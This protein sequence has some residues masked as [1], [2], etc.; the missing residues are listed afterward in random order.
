MGIEPAN[1]L[2]DGNG[3]P[4]SS[5]YQDSYYSRKNGLEES[6]YV[7]I[8][9]NKL[10]QNWRNKHNFTIAETGFG[11]GLNFLAT[12]QYWKNT[13][14]HP[15]Q[16]H[17]ISIEKHPLTR[18]QLKSTLARWHELNAFSALLLDQ[19]PEL[20]PGFHRLHFENHKITLTLC[21]MPANEALEQLDYPIDAWYLDGFS[22][23]KNPD[24]WNYTI[25][26]SIANLSHEKTTLATFTA[27]SLV[28]KQL[29]EAEFNVSKRKGFGKKREMLIATY[30][31]PF[32]SSLPSWFQNTSQNIGK[33]EATLIGGGI[34][35]CQAAWHLAQ[36]G[37]KITLIERHAKLAQEASGNKAGVIT[38]KMTAKE[39]PGETFYIQSFFYV[40]QQLKQLSSDN[41]QTIHWSMSGALQL[42]HNVR[43]S[44]RWQA[45]QERQL[46]LTFLQCVD[47]KKA[48]QIAS[49]SLPTGA[50]YFPQA[51]WLNPASL[52]EALCLHEN[53]SVIYETEALRLEKQNNKWRLKDENDQTI[54]E[55]S[56]VIIANGKDADTFS[57]TQ[58]LPFQPVAGQTNEATAKDSL[59][60]I[61]GHEGYLTPI[62]SQPANKQQCVFGAT[63]ERNQKN[64][65]MM[66]ENTDKNTQ[67]LAN[68]L[69]TF[70]DSLTNISPSHVAV[71]MTTPDRFPYVG[72]IPDESYYLQHYSDLH[73]GKPWK[74]YPPAK[75][76]QGLYIMAGFASRGLT[77]TGLCAE[78]LA[79]LINKEPLPFQKSLLQQLHPAR[80]LVRKLKK[81]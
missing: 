26:Q 69:P 57:Q 20:L 31:Q 36:R 29:L 73:K 18:E 1:I 70:I 56:I 34:A 72:A 68:I 8:E 33:K 28:R 16:L 44:Q 78:M 55:S 61:I 45:L 64:A 42:N 22:P 6:R 48:S 81:K 5:S 15:T 23:A 47:Q 21:F 54:N 49:L 80:F 14:N 39:S 10:S 46:P 79:C 76:Q 50:T 58:F 12:W 67:Q 37:W 51:A 66:P 24:L 3:I 32:S 9:G 53:I 77:T 75:Y 43:E 4:Y 74:T 19:Y 62:I 52:C 13:S 25:L 7:F 40:L 2:L 63:F 60:T 17:Y 11:T 27:A 71:R 41:T 35:A 30:T 65:Q 38:P 59:K